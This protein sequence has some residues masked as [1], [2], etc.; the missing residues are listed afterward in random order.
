MNSL[1]NLVAFKS[2]SAKKCVAVIAAASL[3][4]FASMAVFAEVADIDKKVAEPVQHHKYHDDRKG[5]HGGHFDKHHA[6]FGAKLDLTDAQKETLK[7]T[8][9]ANEAS[10]KALH[11][12]LRTA[13][14]ALD[15][16]VTTNADDALLN[17][18]STDLASLI[19]QKELARAKERRDFLNLLTPEQKQKLEAFNAERK[20]A[21]RWQDRQS[22]DRSLKDRSL[23]DRPVK[24]KQLRDKQLKDGQLKDGQK[25]EPK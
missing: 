20:N 22:K 4:G 1:K 5:K 23:K 15:R 10:Q 3:A 16:A 8:R 6:R 17:S 14:D 13:H 18:L 25:A 2:H 19:A 11:E 7:A 9:T 24:D 12:K 21:P